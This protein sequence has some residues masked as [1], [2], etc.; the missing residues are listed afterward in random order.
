ML[1]KYDFIETEFF[2]LGCACFA[3]EHTQIWFEH[4]NISKLNT[5]EGGK[6]GL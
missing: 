6:E 3:G 4:C 2:I 1:G 5:R